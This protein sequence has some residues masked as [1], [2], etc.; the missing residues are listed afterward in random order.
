[1]LSLWGTSAWTGGTFQ[2]DWDV[3]TDDSDYVFGDGQAISVTGTKLDVRLAGT[4]TAGDFVRILGSTIAYTGQF[5]APDGTALADGDEFTSNGQVYSLEYIAS[6][7]ASGVLLHWLRAAPAPSP[8]PS[9]SPAAGDQLAATGSS[10][11]APAIMLGAVALAGGALLL[12]GR[13][14][15]RRAR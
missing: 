2:V 4:P 7:G 13:R 14:R 5:A 10:D 6:G 15:V 8:S 1:M 12:A 11:A 3:D 9:T